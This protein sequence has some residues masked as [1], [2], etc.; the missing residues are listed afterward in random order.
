MAA[1]DT[2]IS[3]TIITLVCTLLRAK[4]TIR[5]PFYSSF[6]VLVAVFT[7]CSQQLLQ[8]I[9]LHTTQQHSYQ[10]KLVVLFEKY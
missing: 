4:N 3:K 8:P 7:G 5:L 9:R 1:V 6:A 10:Y 2:G